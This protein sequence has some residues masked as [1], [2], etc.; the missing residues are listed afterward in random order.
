MS[1]QGEAFLLIK[2]WLCLYHWD[3][4]QGLEDIGGW[5]NRDCAQWFADYATLIARRYGDRVTRYAAFNEPSVF[6]PFGYCLGGSCPEFPI[7]RCCCA[8]PSLWFPLAHGAAVDRLRVEVTGASLGAIYNCQTVPAGGLRPKDLLA[9]QT[10]DAYWNAAFSDLQLLGRYPPLLADAMAPYQQQDD[11]AL[12]CRPLGWFGLNHY[13]THYVTANADK[14]L[15]AEASRRLRPACLAR[16]WAGRWNRW[17]V[18]PLVRTLVLGG[19]HIAFVHRLF[20]YAAYI[21]AAVLGIIVFE[22]ALRIFLEK[23]LV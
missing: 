16:P 9:A 18:L 11:W 12:I 6:T 15:G 2:P 8:R 21:L 10:L 22:V 23:L 14:P 1:A 17:A 4:P 7:T 20:R 13:S 19:K 5:T 3:L